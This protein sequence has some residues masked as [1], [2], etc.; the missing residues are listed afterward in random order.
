MH[1]RFLALWLF[2]WPIGP[3]VAQTTTATA[4]SADVLVVDHDFVAL[5]EFVRLFL[6]DKQ[7]YRA[8]LSSENVTLQIRPR[9]PGMRTPRI[10]EITSAQS[11]SGSSVVEIYPD[12]D[13]EYE[14][15]AISL[16]GSR[17][18]SRLRLYRD[19][20]ESN[21]RLAP[22]N[23]SP[24]DL[25]F[26]VAGGW[27]SGFS[28]SSPAPA[29][30][31]SLSSGSNVEACFSAR[32]TPGVPRLNLCIL[33][34]S[35]QSQH[36]TGNILWMYT[37]PRV[38]ILGHARPGI[39]NWEA[40]ALLRFGVGVVA[41]GSMKPTVVGP[42]IYVARHLRSKSTGMGWSFQ[43]AYSRP[44]YRGF[45]NATAVNRW[46]TRGSNRVSFGVG[47]YQ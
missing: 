9:V 18:P 31:T 36:G 33:G 43:A 5:G 15:R 8:E 32:S 6:L 47:W 14:L 29:T 41:G 4:D 35:H 1:R 13:G 38:R 2:L 24:W 3:A 27:H 11:P 28:Q 7:V 46:V 37:E 21:R 39:S 20:S 10:Y 42:G 16:H 17:L 40:G 22:S 45:S 25:G 23:H 26:E 30:G 19:V 34:L 44:L 12:Q